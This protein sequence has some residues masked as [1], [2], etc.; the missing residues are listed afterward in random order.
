VIIKRFDLARSSEFI[1]QYFDEE[2]QSYID[3]EDVDCLSDKTKL[4]VTSVASVDA[5]SVVSPERVDDQ[6]VVT[7]QI[8]TV[9]NAEQWPDSLFFLFRR[10]H[11]FDGSFRQRN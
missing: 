7:K 10:F 3:V 6:D 9:P 5:K 4:R 1:L 8:S 2:W 11:H